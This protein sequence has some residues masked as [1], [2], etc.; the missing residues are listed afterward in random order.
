MLEGDDK[1]NWYLWGFSTPTTCYFK[2]HNTRSGDVAHEFLKDSKCEILLSD[3]F[4]GYARAVKLINKHR[5]ENNKPLM[6]SAHCNADS[7]RKFVESSIHYKDQSN[8]FLEKYK[9]IYKNESELKDTPDEEKLK[10]RCS[11]KNIYE[12]MVMQ[13]KKDLKMCSTKSSLAKAI[14]YF[15]DNVTELTLFI[16]DLYIGIDNNPQERNLRSP[17]IGRKTWFGT[18]SKQ[19]ANTAAVLFSLVESCK[20]NKINPRKYFDD[21]TRDLHSGGN[22]FTP[23]EYSKLKNN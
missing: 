16:N 3:V 11:I 7:R 15:L 9:E 1:K 17:V 21:L 13:G 12:E 2:F 14:N 22:G 4:S 10:K 23:F 18:H 19:G 8:Y 6:R 5:M 20:L